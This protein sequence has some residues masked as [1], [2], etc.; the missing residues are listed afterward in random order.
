MGDRK[1]DGEEGTGRSK[2]DEVDDVGGRGEGVDSVHTVFRY[3][4]ASP[5][6]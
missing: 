5:A 6:V 2:R 4:I 3:F 1:G